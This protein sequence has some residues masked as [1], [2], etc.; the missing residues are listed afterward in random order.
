MHKRVG[1]IIEM[2]I[3]IAQSQAPV[4][5]DNQD[6]IIQSQEIFQA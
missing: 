4:R 6:Q 1:E 5:N 3:K 2:N